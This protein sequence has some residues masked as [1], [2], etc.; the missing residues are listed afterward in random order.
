M[1]VIVL[2]NASAGS[3]SSDSAGDAEIRAAF[4]DGGIEAT[5]HSVP[6][7]SL[8]EAAREAAAS[9]V[10]CVVVGGGDGT[11]STVAGALAGTSKPLGIL[12]LGTLNHFAKDLRIPVDLRGAISVIVNGNIK[13]V[14]VAEVNGEVFINNS[15]IGIYPRVVRHRDDQQERLGRGKWLAMFFAIASL[16]NRFPLVTIRVMGDGAPFERRTPFVFIGNNIYELSLFR[17]GGRSALDKGCLCVYIARRH[18]RRG[19][20]LLA[21]R[22][23]FGLLNQSRD[24]DSFC[25]TG[26]SIQ[27]PRRR[28]HVSKDGEVSA[29]TP[30]LQYRVRPGALNVFVPKGEV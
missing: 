10:D 15:C 20:L 28:L 2:L 7:R 1:K 16:F 4:A 17:L 23:V 11:I 25:V 24:F 22:A 27:T 8:A 3:T 5:V 19:I 30:P 21:F 18:T 14:D 12:P 29:M 6:P 9:D 13:S 26:L